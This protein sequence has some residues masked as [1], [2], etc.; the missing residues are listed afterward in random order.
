M[1]KFVKYYSTAGNAVNTGFSSGFVFFSLV[2]NSVHKYFSTLIKYQKIFVILY[3]SISSV[4]NTLFVHIVIVRNHYKTKAANYVSGLCNLRQC[5][6]LFAK[7]YILILKI[8]SFFLSMVEKMPYVNLDHA[9]KYFKIQVIDSLPFA[10]R[11]VPQFDNPEQLFNWLKTRVTY[12]HDPPGVEL[13]QT[14]PR[15]MSE[16]NFHSIPGAGDCDCFTIATLAAC[17]VNGWTNNVGIKLVG[18]QPG[19]PVHIYQY[20]DWNGRRQFLDLTNNSYN[21]ERFYPYYQNLKFHFNT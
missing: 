9:L 2:V 8:T 14:F 19:T 18:R 16:N 13:F 11:Y 17:I 5:S 15:L 20:I 7:T 6:Q 21:S 10:A 1:V 4:I 3:H 12:K